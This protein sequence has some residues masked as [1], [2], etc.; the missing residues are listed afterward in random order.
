[1][2]DLDLEAPLPVDLRRDAARS[3][4]ADAAAAE[5]VAR[6]EAL[7]DGVEAPASPGS[8]RALEIGEQRVEELVAAPFAAREREQRTGVRGQ[9]VAR[10]VHVQADAED[11]C[12]V[13]CFRQEARDLAPPQHDVVRPL[14][15]NCEAGRAL[16][17]V[18]DRDARDE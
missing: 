9:L 3:V 5:E 18:G 15:L 2:A 4:D 17:G 14:E 12:S 7:V 8:V 6:R 1:M 16:D 10:L 11:D 13:A